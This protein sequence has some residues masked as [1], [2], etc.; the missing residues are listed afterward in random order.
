MKNILIIFI[1]LVII[2][3]SINLDQIALENRLYLS[4]AI[5]MI[6]YVW[7]DTWKRYKEKKLNTTHKEW[8]KT[9]QSK[10]LQKLQ[11][12]LLNAKTEEEIK[13]ISKKI[14]NNK[15]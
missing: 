11:K 3:F 14:R 12:E 5:L 10:W 15:I 13:E 7:F 9:I 1:S 4:I 6:A 8:K 2:K